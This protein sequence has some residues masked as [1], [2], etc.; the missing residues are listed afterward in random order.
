MI[1]PKKMQTAQDVADHYDSLDEIY[2][3]LW[4]EHLHH[5]LWKDKRETIERAALNLLDLIAA[6][7]APPQ[8]ARI[9]DIGCGYGASAR[10]FAACFDAKT[11]ALTISETQWQIAKEK[12]VCSGNPEYLFS[13]FLKNALPSNCFDL[14]LAVE[15]FEHMEDK[16]RFFIE[17]FRILKLKGRLALCAWLSRENPKKWETKYLLEPICQE[18][19]LPSLASESEVLS[20]AKQSGFKILKID[21]L[22]REVQRTWTVCIKQALR[23]LISSSSFR[24]YLA[25]RDANEKRFFITLFRLRGA[26]LLG[27]LRYGLFIFEK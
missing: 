12:Q 13:D 21:D 1:R 26:Y 7:A 2:R 8:H 10:Y 11:T 25:S 16:E 4:G 6:N 9:C 19:R 5:G 27:A 14:A 20:M 3:K 24:A 17:A 23:A 22:S 18:G 15:S